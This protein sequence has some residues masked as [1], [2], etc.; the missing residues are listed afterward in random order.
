MFSGCSSLSDI[1]S[2][3][4]W[5]VSNGINFKN[6]FSYCSKLTNINPLQN[7]KVSNGKIFKAMFFKCPFNDKI[8]FTNWK[9]TKEQYFTMFTNINEL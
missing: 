7:W 5:D 3:S 9:I 6:M 4:F 8:H 2:L 1:K